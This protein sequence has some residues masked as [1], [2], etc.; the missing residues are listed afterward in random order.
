MLG[1]AKQVWAL[2]DNILSEKS[3][4]K[5]NKAQEIIDIEKD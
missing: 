3:I 5:I 1:S 4:N 2:Q